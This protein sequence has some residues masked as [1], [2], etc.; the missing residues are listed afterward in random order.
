MRVLIQRSGEASVQVSNRIVGQ[1]DQGL[2]VFVGFTDGDSI[3]Q[4]QYLAKKIVN[5]RIFPDED[6]IMNKSILDYGGKILSVSQFTLYANCK[7]GNRPSYGD[8]MNNHEAIHFYELFNDELRKY[9]TVETGE[10]GA[11]MKVSITNL[12]PTT[13]WLER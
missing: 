9:V 8:A 3:E 12:G 13:I 6:G 5:L 10:F 4:I 7:K 1:I 2:V 11:D